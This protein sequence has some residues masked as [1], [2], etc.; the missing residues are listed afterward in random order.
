MCRLF[1]LTAAPERIHATFWLVDAK[2]SLAE[3]SRGEPDGT[4]VGTFDDRG[5][6]RVDKQPLAAY[7]D[8]AFA[9]EAK[10]L[11][12]TTF[13]AHVRFATTGAI[14][15][16]NTHPFC[17][18][19]RLFAHNGAVGDLPRLEEELGV[20]RSLVKGDTDSERLFALITKHIDDDAGDVGAGITS[21]L[22]WVAAN[23]PV[24]AV[25]LVLTT[26]TELWALRY[27]D[28]HD[29]LVLERRPGGPH[30]SRHLEQASAA[31]T[32]RVRSGHLASVA[33]VVVA[34][35]AM[36]EDPGWRPLESGELLHVDDHLRVRSEIILDRPPHRLLTVDDL[37]LPPRDTPPD[38]GGRPAER[39]SAS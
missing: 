31:S 1:G 9:A 14:D 37:N 26:P 34:T 6:P 15:A 13:V 25:N 29:L 38:A 22:R 24:F 17:Q 36:D 8:A 33:A 2:D 12:S 30:G 28:T 16:K 35:E 4:G 32:I 11:E 19:G 18:N 21:A 3:Q 20:Y 39:H 23:L 10:D 27:P 7:L 5:E